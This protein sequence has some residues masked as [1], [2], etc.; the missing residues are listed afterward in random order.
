MIMTEKV[1]AIQIQ[2]ERV[3]RAVKQKAQRDRLATSS[4]LRKLLGRI[5]S[6]EKRRCDVLEKRTQRAQK[7]MHRASVIA[8]K[9]K[10]QREN[11]ED[12]LARKQREA[13]AR[14]VLR[15]SFRRSI[16]RR[17]NRKVRQKASKVAMK[18][19]ADR[20]R[21]LMKI[22]SR[23]GAARSRRRAHI[24]HIRANAHDVVERVL[25][26]PVGLASPRTPSISPPPYVLDAVGTEGGGRRSACETNDNESELDK[27]L[28]AFSVRCC[29]FVSSYNTHSTLFKSFHCVLSCLT[30]DSLAF[31]SSSSSTSDE[32][33]GSDATARLD[34][35]SFLGFGRNSEMLMR[36][37]VRRSAQYVMDHIPTPTLSMTTRSG[38]MLLVAA[39]LARYPRLLHCNT[40]RGGIEE[41]EDD[42]DDDDDDDR[43]V[44]AFLSNTLVRRAKR[45]IAAC[46]RL[47]SEMDGYDDGEES[48][49]CEHIQCVNISFA[50]FCKSF[51]L[52]RHASRETLIEDAN[53]SRRKLSAAMEKLERYDGMHPFEKQAAIG[54]LRSQWKEIERHIA[55]L[56]STRDI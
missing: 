11:L 32:D 43:R 17:K 46:K 6:A 55:A 29:Q 28:R 14:R 10:T 50:S 51:R 13:H 21:L 30:N 19:K 20:E 23:I 16:K 4:S 26:S 34:Y 22:E 53:A 38:R 9:R 35:E 45:L 5:R 36:E 27:R 15:K 41:D 2:H 1:E 52:W 54:A 48:A 7:A 18:R 39:L 8:R 44:C 42:V 12:R 3:A 47:C 49:L 37:N 25:G 33:G 56:V 40:D 31:P 24:H